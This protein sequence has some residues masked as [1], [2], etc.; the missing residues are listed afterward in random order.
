MVT[1]NWQQ[2]MDKANTLA[3]RDGLPFRVYS[4]HNPYAD[5]P[6]RWAYD[7]A[8]VSMQPAHTCSGPEDPNAGVVVINRWDLICR[9]CWYEVP[10]EKVRG[11]SQH[12]YDD[13][14]PR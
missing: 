8:P 2:A 13:R 12:A 1:M 11:E 5:P 3:K 6:F 7:V 14:P 4:I 10:Y 9:A